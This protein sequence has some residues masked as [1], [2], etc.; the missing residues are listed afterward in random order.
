MKKLYVI[1]RADLEPGD[2]IAQTGHAVANFS[3]RH[4]E[5]FASWIDGPNNLVV[6]AIADETEMMKL[7][8]RLDGHAVITVR[9]PDLGNSMTAVAFPGGAAA[10]L[11][12]SLPLAMKSREAA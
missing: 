12:A 9:E 11:V 7:L 4:R 10:K 1:V 5:L 3:H 2:Q 8:V 6:L